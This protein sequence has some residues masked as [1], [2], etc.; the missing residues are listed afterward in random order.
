MALNR[1]EFLKWMGTGLVMVATPIHL[2]HEPSGPTGYIWCERCK[3][4]H[5]PAMSMEEFTE[6]IIKPA[7]QRLADS[8]DD[9]IG[10][11]LLKGQL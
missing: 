4:F 7:A 8:I 2:A 5:P 1:R 3:C 10:Q 9:S 6:A 11:M